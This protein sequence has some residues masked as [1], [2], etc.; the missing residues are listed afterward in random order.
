MGTFSIGHWIFSILLFVV[1]L[2]LW[3]WALIDIL[4]ST[5]KDTA[6]K[7]VWLLVVIFLP[8]IGVIIYYFVGRK[9]KILG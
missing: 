8:V 4:K 1:P 6:T 2:I 9:Q 5:F 3:V 7:I